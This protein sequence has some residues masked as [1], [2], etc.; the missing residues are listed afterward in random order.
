MKRG[1]WSFKALIPT[2]DS[3][4]G[5]GQGTGSTAVVQSPD[6]S[7]GEAEMAEE[8]DGG[9]RGIGAKEAASLIGC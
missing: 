2:L 3:P 8:G 5:P 6:G 4:P 7:M 9:K 1:G